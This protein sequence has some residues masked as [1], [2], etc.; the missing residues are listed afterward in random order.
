[1][2]KKIS[3][4]VAGK[5]VRSLGNNFW[6]VLFSC[7]LVA[8]IEAGARSAIA[9]QIEAGATPALP[10][11]KPNKQGSPQVGEADL[12]KQRGDALYKAEDFPH[13]LDQYDQYLGSTESADPDVTYR[14]GVCCHRIGFVLRAKNAFHKASNLYGNSLNGY[15]A[16]CDYYVLNREYEKALQ[17]AQEACRLFP[18]EFQTYVRV[19]LCHHRICQYRPAIEAYSQALEVHAKMT[20]TKDKQFPFE[21]FPGHPTDTR[22]FALRGQCFYKIGKYAQAEADCTKLLQTKTKKVMEGYES[23]GEARVQLGDF[24]GASKDFEAAIKLGTTRARTSKQL[25]LCQLK[26]GLNKEAC[27]NFSAA[28]KLFPNYAEAHRLRSETL[29]KLGDD[30]LAQADALMAR[31]LGFRSSTQNETV[32]PKGERD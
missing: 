22:I 17:T 9:D 25:G 20:A 24:V 6:T 32:E 5:S 28:I 10:A 18:N 16:R 31:K 3:A 7:T 19:A 21:E 27:A 23:R 11:Q 12:G 26:L 13:A 8:H 4:R 14:I 2:G 29:K 1:M 15:L 30:K